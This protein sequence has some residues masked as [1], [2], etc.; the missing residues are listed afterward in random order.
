M[1]FYQRGQSMLSRKLLQSEQDA[2]ELF[3]LA[4]DAEG[5]EFQDPYKANLAFLSKELLQERRKNQPTHLPKFSEKLNF[6]PRY[7]IN[8]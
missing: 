2:L 7:K 8:F 5:R 6:V 1:I 3:Q 4:P